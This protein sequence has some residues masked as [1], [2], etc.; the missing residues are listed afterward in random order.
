MVV[1]VIVVVVMIVVVV[2]DKNWGKGTNLFRNN[3]YLEMFF[4]SL[5]PAGGVLENLGESWG[6]SEVGGGWCK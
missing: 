5:T 4:Q 1:M 2:V 3:L 6:I